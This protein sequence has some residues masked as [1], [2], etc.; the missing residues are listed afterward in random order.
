MSVTCVHVCA[1]AFETHAE[2]HGDEA[3]AVRGSVRAHDSV[4][5]QHGRARVA[6]PEGFVLCFRRAHEGCW[7]VA[8]GTYL[9]FCSERCFK[10]RSQ[11]HQLDSA[12]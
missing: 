12:V 5:G 11:S 2:R 3:R 10:M 8:N 9:Q 4:T 7:S 6:V 1:G